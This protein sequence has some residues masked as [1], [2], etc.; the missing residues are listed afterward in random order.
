MK[1]IR[2]VSSVGRA[3]RLHREGRKFKSCTAHTMKIP[4]R[5][6][7]L[8]FY[9][10]YKHDPSGPVNNYAY[11]LVGV[12]CHTEEDC[13]SEDANMAVYRP[14]YEEASV[15]KAGKLFDLRPLDM[16]MEEI[17]KNGKVFPRFQKIT[18]PETVAHLE[19][20][21]VRMYEL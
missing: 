11:E 6:P 20:V 2:A 17:N 1:T 21:K 13:R 8:G 18:D 10:H 14:L 12:G 4:P 7:A 9:Y 15:Y 3:T 5:V 16:W 19:K